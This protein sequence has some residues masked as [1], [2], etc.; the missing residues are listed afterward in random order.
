V[1]HDYTCTRQLSVTEHKF[2][3]FHIKSQKIATLKSVTDNHFHFNILHWLQFVMSLLQ[4]VMFRY[5]SIVHH[6]VNVTIN[7]VFLT[8]RL[9]LVWFAKGTVEEQS[10]KYQPCPSPLYRCQR[11]LKNQHW[12]KYRKELA[13]CR[14]DA[15]G[16]WSKIRH[17]QENEILQV[18]QSQIIDSTS[19]YFTKAALWWWTSHVTITHLAYHILCLHAKCGRDW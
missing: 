13:R 7:I 15:A 6:L 8:G 5:I 16:E 10:G 9:V 3:N 14:Y 2:P 4:C 1:K 11:M 17:R 12:T 18:N 19:Y